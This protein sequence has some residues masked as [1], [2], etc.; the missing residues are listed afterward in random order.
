M[1]CKHIIKLVNSLYTHTFILIKNLICLSKNQQI[2]FIILAYS[3]TS[4]EII[5]VHFT[6]K[7]MYTTV[8]PTIMFVVQN[9]RL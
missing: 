7:I 4:L 1:V 2:L 8:L 9:N 6:I 5:K 3:K